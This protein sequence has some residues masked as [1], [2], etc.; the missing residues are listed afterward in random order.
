MT[1]GPFAAGTGTVV[2]GSTLTLTMAMAGRAVYRD[3]LTGP[4]VV[5]LRERCATA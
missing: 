2:S 5:T 3:E 4:G 1:D